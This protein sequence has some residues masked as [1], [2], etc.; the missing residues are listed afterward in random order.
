MELEG[1]LEATFLPP[2]D[3]SILWCHILP[4]Q[5]VFFLT[6]KKEAPPALRR[7]SNTMKGF[8]AHPLSTA[9]LASSSGKS[10][11]TRSNLVGLQ[12]FENILQMT[13]LSVAHL[14]SIFKTVF[15][16]AG[17]FFK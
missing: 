4:L 1:L 6:W 11:G 15:K 9:K 7:L 12:T 14:F 2:A 13:V 5:E 17:L 8:C 16:P 3:R 10:L